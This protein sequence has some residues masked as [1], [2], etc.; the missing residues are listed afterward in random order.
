[1]DLLPNNAV[2]LSKT[3]G[4]AV[5]VLFSL[6]VV[7]TILFLLMKSYM[8]G[9]NKKWES[10]E[11]HTVTV[12]KDMIHQVTAARDKDLQLLQDALADNR[13]QIGI[14]RGLVERIKAM[15]QSHET[16]MRDIFDKLS[17]ILEDRCRFHI[18]KS[19]SQ[20]PK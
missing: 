9:E 18:I 8:S 2:E 3:L 16:A 7:S 12:Y 10:H 19:S 5:M 14:N 4:I 15:Q 6:I 11:A 17:R 13:E 1:M 20:T